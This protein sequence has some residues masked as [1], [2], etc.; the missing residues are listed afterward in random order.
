MRFASVWQAS[1]RRSL[2]CAVDDDGQLHA[3]GEG[4]AD[5]AALIAQHGAAHGLGA[6]AQSL[7]AA[8]PLGHL[9][10]IA[11]SQPDLDTQHLLAPARPAEVWAAGVTYELSRDA[12]IHESLSLI[13]I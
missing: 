10:A 8:A 9:D 3:V 2:L 11:S 12:R 5:V 1:E 4:L 7:M 6:A 13:H